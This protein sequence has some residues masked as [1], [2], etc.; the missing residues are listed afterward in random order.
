MFDKNKPIP[1][2]SQIKE[3]LEED[4]LSN[5]LQPGD[6]FHSDREL[7]MRFGVSRGTV[8]KTLQAM[9]NEGLITRRAGQGTFVASREKQPAVTELETIG[10][11]MYAPAME[12]H[13]F[14]FKIWRAI[15]DIAQ[16]DDRHILLIPYSDSYINKEKSYLWDVVKKKGIK[17]V[18]IT[19]EEVADEEIM[20]LHDNHVPVVL[21]DR[22][23]PCKEIPSIEVDYEYKMYQA[24]RY[25]KSLGHKKIAYIGNEEKFRIIRECMRFFSQGTQMLGLSQDKQLIKMGGRAG[26]GTFQAASELFEM[27]S[28]PTAVIVQDPF[29]CVGVLNA[30]WPRQIAVPSQLSIISL[31]EFYLSSILAPTLSSYEINALEMTHVAFETLDKVMRGQKTKSRKFK[32][33]L[34]KRD[35]CVEATKASSIEKKV[36]AE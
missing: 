28:P 6:P 26:I 1:L 24:L 4:I 23:T 13:G 5:K 17:G 35:S 10:I 15:G 29:H 9:E 33:K 18:I 8:R 22:Y 11:V 32:S 36:A 31:A 3:I 16:R 21:L 12:A 27:Q 25:L 2:H 30:C 19:A 34:I 20:M 7:V 14:M